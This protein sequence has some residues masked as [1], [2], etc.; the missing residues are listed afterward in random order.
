[1]RWDFHPEALEEYR[2][3][4]L[5][6]TDREPSVALRFVEAVEDAIRRILEMPFAWRALDDEVRRC[7]T[8]RFPYGVLFTVDDDYILIV[9]VMHTSREPGYWRHRLGR[10]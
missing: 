9:A 3:A 2:E 8:H 1:M 5:Y 6:Y 4:A 7:L 10:T